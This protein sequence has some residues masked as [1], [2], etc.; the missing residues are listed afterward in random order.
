M[1][2]WTHIAEKFQILFEP[3]RGDI[4]VTQPKNQSRTSPVGATLWNLAPNGLTILRVHIAAPT[5]LN[6]IYTSFFYQNVAP[7]GA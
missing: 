5:G 1:Y 4:M 2:R 6:Y 3:Y 7:S